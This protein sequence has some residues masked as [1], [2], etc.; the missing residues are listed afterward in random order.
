[1]YRY[2]KSIDRLLHELMKLPGVGQKTAE[3]YLFHLLRQPKESLNELQES[4][5]HLREE[6][7]TCSECQNFADTDPC[8]ICADPARDRSQVCVVADG[9]TV[10]VLEKTGVYRGLYHILGGVV[11]A[12]HGITPESLTIPKLLERIQK[13]QVH[14]VIIA[15]NPDMSG[16]TTALYIRDQLKELPVTITRLGRGLPLG[17]D[18]GYA[19]EETLASALEGR[20]NVERQNNNPSVR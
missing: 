15:T 20:Q 13:G 18:I 17:A 14:E 2:P 12:S 11:N 8:S 4:V 10:A 7:I 16:D 6:I 3:R 9:S 19:D 1:M 5:E